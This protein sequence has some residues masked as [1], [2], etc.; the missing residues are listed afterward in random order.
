MQLEVKNECVFN[1]VYGAN[2]YSSKMLLHLSNAKMKVWSND[3]VKIYQCVYGIKWI[4][5]TDR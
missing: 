1:V 4:R 3:T 5:I 2:R